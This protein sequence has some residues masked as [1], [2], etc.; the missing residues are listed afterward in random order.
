MLQIKYLIEVSD[1]VKEL[2]IHLAT[3]IEDYYEP[4]K[5]FEIN[6]FEE[7]QA[8]QAKQNF[9]QRYLASFIAYDQNL[10]LFAGVWEITN[11]PEWREDYKCYYYKTRMIDRGTDLVGRLI[12]FYERTARQAY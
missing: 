1:I 8:Y 6:E 5:K 2:K 11:E 12:V 7:W 9:S 10:W 4:L 3:G